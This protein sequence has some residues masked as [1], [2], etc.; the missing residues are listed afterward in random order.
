MRNNSWHLLLTSLFLIFL[1]MSP[2]GLLSKSKRPTKSTK[3]T[4]STKRKTSKKISVNKWRYKYKVGLI[5]SICKKGYYFRNCYKIIRKNC[6]TVLKNNINKCSSF[7][8]RNRYITSYSFAKKMA[9][10]ISHCVH[11]KIIKRHPAF[12]R[13]SRKKSCDFS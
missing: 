2:S 3:S 4:K 6:I 13:N 9:D 11:K 8:T 10:K 5:K 1:F 7:K 12:K